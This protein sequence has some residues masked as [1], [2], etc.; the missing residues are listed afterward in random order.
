MTECKKCKWCFEDITDDFLI[1]SD[2]DYL[3]IEC[4]RELDKVLEEN[5]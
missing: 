1:T 3:H 4:F 5:K 2:G